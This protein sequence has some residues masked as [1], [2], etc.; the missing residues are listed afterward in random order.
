MA[1]INNEALRI[2][3]LLLS[4]SELL[5][6]LLA[7]SKVQTVPVRE[8]KASLYLVKIVFLSSAKSLN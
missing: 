6:E 2:V 1:D 8:N 5:S 4:S 7:S 3:P